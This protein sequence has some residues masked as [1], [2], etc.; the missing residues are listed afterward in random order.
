MSD[1]LVAHPP[2]PLVQTAVSAQ[3]LGHLP[4]WQRVLQRG[5]GCQTRYLWDET[6]QDGVAITFFKRA[7][8]HVGFIGFPFGQTVAGRPLTDAWLAR[9]RRAK[10]DFPIAAFRVVASPFLEQIA[11]PTKGEVCW[12]TAVSQLH[13][14]RL[15]DL[16]SSIR[17]NIKKASKHGVQIEPA[18]TAAAAAQISTLYHQTV[19]RHQGTARYTPAYFDALVELASSEPLL[20]CTVA[21]HNGQLIA[22]HIAAKH[23]TTVFYLHGGMD[24]QFQQLRANDLLFARAFA[25]AEQRGAKQFN[26]M[27]S[28]VMQPSLVRFKEKWGGVTKKQHTFNLPSS[29]WPGTGFRLAYAIYQQGQRLKKGS[30][31]DG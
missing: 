27:A 18:E 26:L 3:T 22:F 12:E 23:G 7:I 9:L 15:T 21:R 29:G 16:S 20:R 11:P 28:P 2:P 25:W 13:N 17:R 19:A 30:N 14:W 31:S 24:V 1:L 4:R 6:A 5:L 10:T 8:F